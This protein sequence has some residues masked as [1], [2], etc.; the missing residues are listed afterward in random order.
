[1]GGVLVGGVLGTRR[2]ETGEGTSG[3][4]TVRQRYRPRDGCPYSLSTDFSAQRKWSGCTR[5]LP[6][7][8]GKN[9][10]PNEAGQDIDHV[11]HKAKS[12][13]V[14]CRYAKG[15]KKKDKGTLPDSQTGNADWEDWEDWEI[16]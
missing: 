15:N 9:W 14:L 12:D 11:Q 4:A 10:S 13:C 5:L 1:M 8:H 2:R 6:A 16:T 7:A 3:S